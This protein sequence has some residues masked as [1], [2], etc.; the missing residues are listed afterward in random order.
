MSD[1]LLKWARKS[2]TD[3]NYQI[4]NWTTTRKT[5]WGN[6]GQAILAQTSN[7]GGS[8]IRHLLNQKIRPNYTDLPGK[9]WKQLLVFSSAPPGVSPFL[10]L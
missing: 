1:R 3:K 2:K 9:D 10:V 8:E 4:Y 5:L 7:S 6:Q